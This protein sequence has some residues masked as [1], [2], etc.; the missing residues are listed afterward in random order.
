M[1]GK[2]EKVLI[3]VSNCGITP[4]GAG[5]SPHFVVSMIPI[6]DHPRRC[7]EKLF[8]ISHETGYQ[9]SPP[10]VRGKAPVAL[11]VAVTGG[12][13]PA[14]AGKSAYPVLNLSVFEDHPRRCGEKDIR[15]ARDGV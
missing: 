13:T 5:K 7:G 12:I 14:G 11:W 9:G 3:Y 6:K 8:E 2:V 15:A 10:Q 4:A 1:R